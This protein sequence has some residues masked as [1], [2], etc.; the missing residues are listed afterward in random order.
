MVNFLVKTREGCGSASGDRARNL[1]CECC[2]WC[3]LW[4]WSAQQRFIRGNKWPIWPNWLVLVSNSI[5]KSAT[6]SFRHSTA[7]SLRV[8]FR[9]IG[10]YQRNFQKSLYYS[11]KNGHFWDN[12]KTNYSTFTFRFWIKDILILRYF[13]IFPLEKVYPKVYRCKCPKFNLM[14]FNANEAP[15]I[16]V[17][18]YNNSFKYSDNASI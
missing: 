2:Y 8:L 13:V 1:L 18:S 17:I 5:K 6:R 15:N 10:S 9:I 3:W 12:D 4:D 16:L 14:S 11:A 7:A